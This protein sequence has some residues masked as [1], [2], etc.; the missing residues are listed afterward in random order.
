MRKATDLSKSA[1]LTL[2][3]NIL[4]NQ[5]EITQTQLNITTS[6]T[7]AATIKALIQQDQATRRANEE[8]IFALRNTNK[9]AIFLQDISDLLPLTGKYITL[10]EAQKAENN[11]D[12]DI[13]KLNIF[14]QNQI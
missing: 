11:I 3:K 6:R 1:A 5:K 2:Q 13:P 10:E 8:N 12:I 14:S 9:A 7:R 4:E